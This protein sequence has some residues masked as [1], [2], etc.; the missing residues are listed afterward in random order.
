MRKRDREGYFMTD[1]RH[2]GAPMPDA[3]QVRAGLPPGSGRGLFE[4]ATMK[5][6]HCGTIVILNPKRDRQRGYCR[7]C[8]AYV[9][10]DPIC[11]SRC[12]PIKKR[13]EDAQEAALKGLPLPVFR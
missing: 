13:L 7:T 4:S 1:H 11:N 9:C 2:A 10:D 5:C 3:I 6:N 8:D 12:Y